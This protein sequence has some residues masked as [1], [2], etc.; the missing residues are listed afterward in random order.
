MRLR[1]LA[2]VSGISRHQLFVHP[3]IPYTSHNSA[4]CLDMEWLAADLGTL[5]D[6]TRVYLAEASAPGSDAAFCIAPFDEIDETVT[7]YGQ[8]RPRSKF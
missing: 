6:Y 2:K 1:G 3:D 8:Q 7:S 4:L 5:A